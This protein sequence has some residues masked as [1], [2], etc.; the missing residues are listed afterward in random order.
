MLFNIDPAGIKEK[1]IIIIPKSYENKLCGVGKLIQNNAIL[2]LIKI[3]IF[4][5]S[6]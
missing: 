4:L 1:R 2:Y 3:P 6:K 5:G